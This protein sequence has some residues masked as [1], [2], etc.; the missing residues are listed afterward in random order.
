MR[1]H[2]SALPVSAAPSLCSL[3]PSFD[4]P[5]VDELAGASVRVASPE[6]AEL[7]LTSDPPSL[8]AALSMWVASLPAPPSPPLAP[9]FEPHPAASAANASVGP[10]NRR[11]AIIVFS[12]ST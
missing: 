3:E 2:P 8:P 10:A 5:S 7:A 6:S 11:M 1:E 4:D 12:F 9:L